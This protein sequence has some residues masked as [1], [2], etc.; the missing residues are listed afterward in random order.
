[1]TRQSTPVDDYSDLLTRPLDELMKQWLLDP[2][3]LP[4]TRI[5]LT[6]QDIAASYVFLASDESRGMTGRFLHPDGGASI[7]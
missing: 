2:A 5:A 3:E 7:R 6:P 1:M 4:S